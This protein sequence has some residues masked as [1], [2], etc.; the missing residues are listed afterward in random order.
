MQFEQGRAHLINIQNIKRLLRACSGLSGHSMKLLFRRKRSDNTL[1]CQDEEQ[2]AQ[3]NSGQSGQ[4]L[5]QARKK[6]Y[7][8]IYVKSQL[9]R[10]MIPP[11]S[12]QFIESF[13]NL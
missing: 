2:T 3:L 1:N 13:K 11:W 10:T 4:F 6:L 12:W 8:V 5:Q 9:M 7:C